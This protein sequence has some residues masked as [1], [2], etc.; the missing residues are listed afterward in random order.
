MYLENVTI[1]DC[2]DMWEK[3]G[4]ATIISSGQVA[5]FVK[6]ESKWIYLNRRKA[7]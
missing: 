2:L 5:R 3:K 6:E 4:K 7:T 1:Q